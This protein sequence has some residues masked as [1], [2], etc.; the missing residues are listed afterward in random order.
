M[1]RL[2][3][4]FKERL[5]KSDEITL[6]FKAGNSVSTSGAKLFFRRNGRDYNRI[7][8]AFSRKFGNAV[9]RNRARR[10]GRE[11]YRHLRH[12]LK[13]GFDIVLLVYPDEAADFKKR[14]DALKV[15]FRKS[16][17]LQMD[18]TA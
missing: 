17:I 2:F 7:A 8:C 4:P 15:L 16:R 18:M 9:R 6:V 13:Q 14:F 10:L 11:A 12:D 3:F 1:E 5:K